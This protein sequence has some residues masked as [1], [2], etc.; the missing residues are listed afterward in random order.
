MA[1]CD[2][3]KPPRPEQPS[4][5]PIDLLTA[6]RLADSQNP[7]IAVARERIREAAAQTER[8]EL[9]WLP[10]LELSPAWMRHDGQIQRV[11]GPVITASKS[12]VFAGGGPTLSLALGDAIYAPLAARQIMTARQ[13]G[14][15]GLTNERLLDVAL[16]Y[17]DLWQTE[18]ELRISEET[19]DNARHL[20]ELTESY[21]RS[22][23]GAAADTAR[24]RTE[25]NVR[26]R[27]RRDLFARDSLASARLTELLRLP[28][29]LQ[30]RPT[31]SALVP[32][33]LVPEDIRI[34]ELLA[35]GLTNRLELAEN[36]ALIAAALERWRSAKVA[37]LL[38]SLKL[39]YSGGVFGG[40][41]NDFVGNFDGRS[42]VSAMAVWEFKNLAFGDAAL[43][44][45]RYSQFAQAAFRQDAVEGRVAEQIVAAFRQAAA[46]REVLDMAQEAVKAAR[47]SYRLNE[48]R[49]RRAPEQGRPIELLQALQALARA[50]AD[51]IQVVTDF[52]RAQFRLY[53]ALGNP[54]L[55]ALEGA[56]KMNL[57][58]PVTPVPTLPSPERVRPN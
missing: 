57:A 22:G 56:R 8:A 43:I 34:Q 52:N 6:L 21:E 32:L 49:I 26:L 16:A 15:A 33:V 1:N 40:G 13:A 4:E 53:T 37:P 7:E 14:A 45:E 30:L 50:R 25:M 46:S 38:P 47:E 36:R 44:R 2:P 27:E 20:L 54:P 5:A 58:E 24:A 51:Y 28:P 10:N 3:A 35:Q 18:A 19:L 17:I 29:E 39:T 55:C 12:S 31:E 11:E 48:E 41:P 9:L 42:D 23:K